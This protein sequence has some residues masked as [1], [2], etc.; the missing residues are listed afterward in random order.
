VLKQALEDI[1]RWQ[2]RGVCFARTRSIAAA[3]KSRRWWENSAFVQAIRQP[4]WRDALSVS[5]VSGA[6]ND[7]GGSTASVGWTS[8]KNGWLGI[9]SRGDL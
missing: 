7:L 6:P 3:P 9:K 4:Q 1:R 5:L 2:P 8:S